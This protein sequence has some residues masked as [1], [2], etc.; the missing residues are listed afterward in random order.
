MTYVFAKN[1]PLLIFYI[2]SRRSVLRERDIDKTTQ[3]NL[4]II[5]H[6]HQPCNRPSSKSCDYSTSHLVMEA[7]WL[8]WSYGTKYEPRLTSSSVDLI[9]LKEV[10]VQMG[11]WSE[12]TVNLCAFRC[13]IDSMNS[14]WML[15]D[16]RNDQVRVFISFI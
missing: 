2:K 4:I 1:C 10:L 15:L 14:L 3:T 11:V 7:M 6:D 12:F 16:L 9:M 5:L 13:E 8:T